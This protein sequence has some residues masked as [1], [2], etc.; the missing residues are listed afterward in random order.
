MKS[1]LALLLVATVCPAEK[2]DRVLPPPESRIYHGVYPG[3]VSGEEDDLAPKDVDAYEEHVGARVAWVYFSHN[4]YAGRAFPRKT[5]EWIRERG[6]VPFIRLMLRSSAEQD[7]EEPEF[8]VERIGDGDFDD[9]LTE[10]A[11]DAKGFGTPLLVEWGTEMNGEWFSWNGKRHGGGD[12]A[13][14]GDPKRPDGPERF[15]AAYRRIVETM[16]RAGADNLTWVF[17]VNAN[18][19]PEEEWNRFE[20]Y[21]PGDD[22][23]DWVGISAYGPQ[24]PSDD[25]ASSFRDMMDTAVKRVEE[26][27]PGKPIVALEFGC[28][29]GSKAARPEQWAAAALDDLLS[30]RWK[31]IVGFSWWNERWE[32]D[33]DP[34]HDTTMR[35]QDIAPLAEAFRTRLTKAK[36]RLQDRPVLGK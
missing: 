2:G 7:V 23:V 6:S 31:S 25:E 11:R 32:N 15:A 1:L 10:W 30:I 36:D 22:V 13:E 21:Y 26:L 20:E 16:R 5:A 12:C 34:S 33:E 9:D 18:D 19:A 4:W 29:A 35:V 17:H 3:G 28:T 8:T 24:L 27:A 14:F